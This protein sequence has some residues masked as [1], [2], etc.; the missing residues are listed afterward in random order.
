M[1]IIRILLLIILLL[2]SKSLMGE[3]NERS[4]VQLANQIIDSIKE[5][6]VEKFIDCWELPDHFKLYLKNHTSVEYYQ[7]REKKLTE[8]Y[9]AVY[10]SLK[11]YFFNLQEELVKSGFD[12]NDIEYSSMQ[13]QVSHSDDVGTKIGGMTIRYKFSSHKKSY[14]ISLDD[15]FLFEKK[16]WSFTDYPKSYNFNYK[17][18]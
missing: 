14:Q 3:N 11:P 6:D 9:Y 18:K 1:K 10:D 17:I 7:K 8:Y 5:D 12:K 4:L 13:C 15:G 2:C 16:R